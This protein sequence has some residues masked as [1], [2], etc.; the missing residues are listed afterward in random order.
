MAT[1]QWKVIGVFM[2][3]IALSHARPSLKI[4]G[5]DAALEDEYDYNLDE[6]N[7]GESDMDFANELGYRSSDS[8][9]GDPFRRL[10]IVP[11]ITPM[12]PRKLAAMVTKHGS[13]SPS[14]FGSLKA[15]AIQTAKAAVLLTHWLS[16]V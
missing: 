11:Y 2:L 6:L 10:G 14:F 16:R 4:D 3:T 5:A 1:I 15:A 7:N 9:M 8:F 13:R 12:D